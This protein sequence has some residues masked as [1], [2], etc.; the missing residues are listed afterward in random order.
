MASNDS[1]VGSLE[2]TFETNLGES[3]Y[4]MSALETTWGTNLGESLYDMSELLESEQESLNNNSNQQSPNVPYVNDDEVE[5]NS[6]AG[7]ITELV[8]QLEA[9]GDGAYQELNN[10]SESEPPKKKPKYEV[11]RKPPSISN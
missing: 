4:D 3:L 8:N 2:T 10:D 1:S 6:V 5:Q 11:P 7:T 9:Q